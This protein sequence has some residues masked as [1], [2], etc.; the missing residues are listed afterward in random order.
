M[1]IAAACGQ[2][3]VVKALAERQ[4]SLDITDKVCFEFIRAQKQIN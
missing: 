3:M 2:I 1:L 4:V